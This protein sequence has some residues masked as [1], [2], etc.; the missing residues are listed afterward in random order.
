M[1]VTII[2]PVYNAKNTILETIESVRLQTYLNYE[3]IIVDGLSD[4]GTLDVIE[5]LP[6]DGR[7]S[8]YSEK[9]RGL[10]DA[11]NK[12]LKLSSGEIIGVLNADDVF[13]DEN[14]LGLIAASFSGDINFVYSDLYYV[15]RNDLSIIVRAW[16]S[17]NFEKSMIQLGW[18][19]PHP[20]VYMLKDFMHKV[21]TYDSE[22]YKI[23]SDYDY[24]LRALSREDLKIHYTNHFVIKMRAGGVS[25]NSLFNCPKKIFEDYR[26]LRNS[27]CG[28]ILTV[29]LK[30]IRKLPQ[31]LGVRL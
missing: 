7:M 26:A 19:P 25:N 21:G 29:L 11:I 28:G 22:N 2:T 13:L 1:K 4:D 8:L 23:S 10:Y 31:Y 30:R 6:N 17:R 20:T 16:K 12:G 27:G 18:M 9:D 15:K 3:H 14:S 5:S 24:L